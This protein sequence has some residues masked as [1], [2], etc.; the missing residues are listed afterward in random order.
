[1]LCRALTA[2]D[3]SAT[4]RVIDGARVLAALRPLPRLT[5]VNVERCQWLNDDLGEQIAAAAARATAL[6]RAP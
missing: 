4:D 2:F 1:M 5:Q 6:D 3:L